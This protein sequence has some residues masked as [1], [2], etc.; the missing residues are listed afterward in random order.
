[1]ST[2]LYLLMSSIWWNKVLWNA[3]AIVYRNWRLATIAL[4]VTTCSAVISYVAHCETLHWLM[5][6][7]PPSL[8]A[9]AEE[10]AAYMRYVR[11]LDFFETPDYQYLVKLFT[12]LM[13]KNGWQC[14]WEFDWV[15]RQSVCFV[16]LFCLLEIYC[17]LFC[18]LIKG[19]RWCD[20]DYIFVLWCHCIVY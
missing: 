13:S 14:N 8:C 20:V 17:I 9:C 18:L 4:A 1:M 6:Y 2:C 7:C 16:W 3:S 5:C 15:E 19:G 10:V 11:R 12:D